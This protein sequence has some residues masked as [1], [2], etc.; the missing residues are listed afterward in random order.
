MYKDKKFDISMF[1]NEDIDSAKAFEELSKH[2]IKDI[3]EYYEGQIAEIKREFNVKN[4][5]EEYKAGSDFA[6]TKREFME[7]PLMGASFQ[8]P[9]MNSIFRGMYGFLLRVAKS[10]GGKAQPIDTI[11][12]TPN[13]YK[14]LGDIKVG[15][16]VYDRLGKPTKVL[17]VFPQGMLDCYTVTLADGRSTQCNDEHLWSYWDVSDKKRRN[18][19]VLITRTLKE[20]MEF[21]NTVYI[22]TNKVIEYS[23][24]DYNIDPYVIGSFIGN[25]CCKERMLT[26]SSND[27]EQVRNVAN[28]LNAK[29]IK[30]PYNYSWHFIDEKQDNEENKYNRIYLQ[31]KQLFNKYKDEICTYSYLKKIPN[32]YKYGSVEQRLNLLQGLFDT[33]GSISVE[34][35]RYNVT[36]TTTSLNLANDIAEVVRSLGYI[37]SIRK[38]DRIKMK[39]YKELV[40]FYIYQL[41]IQKNKNSL[42]YLEN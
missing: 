3:I 10:G 11:I 35:G 17:G 22:P 15:D 36:Y 1:Y 30:C 20:I 32:E 40:T 42:D 26:L 28:L 41:I 23:K 16:Y 34:G 25:G 21:S 12:P 31:T 2:S 13:G 19:D 33:D 14:K 18:K 27:E 9:Y 24:K 37:C 7:E 4:N 6:E 5:A 29:Y 38:H 39:Y 8:S